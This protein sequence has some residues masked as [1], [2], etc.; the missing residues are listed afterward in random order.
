MV[1]V[2]I[3]ELDSPESAIGVARCVRR[4]GYRRVEAFTPFPIPALDEALEIPRTK[5]PYVVLA[6]GLSGLGIALLIEWWTN[7]FDYP[8]DVGGRPLGSYPAWVP[9]IFETTVLVASL[10]AFATVILL[11]RL[12]R[13]H[14]PLFD[15]PGFQRTSIDRF[16]ILIGD[17][18]SA[19]GDVRDEEVALLRRELTAF[20]AVI[21]RGRLPGGHWK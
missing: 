21:I 6:A 12:P 20:G 15:L 14:N 5:L 9:I 18:Y 19:A 2:L 11:S 4:L 7:A 3:A 8:L 17:A 1:E 16:W 10:T 13:L